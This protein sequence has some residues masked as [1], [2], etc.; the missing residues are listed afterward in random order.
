VTSDVATDLAELLL[1]FRST[2]G[3][4]PD[5]TSIAIAV[6]DED[7]CRMVA[8]FARL[9]LPPWQPVDSMPSGESPRDLHERWMWLWAG[10]VGGP[11]DPEFLDE[12][13]RRANV[14]PRRARARWPA[15]V[16]SRLV[17]PDGS[18]S[19]AGQM[20]VRSFVFERMPKPAAPPRSTK[21]GG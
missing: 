1:P 15:L 18:L 17:F 6:G 4:P 2:E 8:A 21:R 5:P 19:E 12:L 14:L 10:Y 3:A 9:A 16:A 13:A 7:S 20:L 11:D